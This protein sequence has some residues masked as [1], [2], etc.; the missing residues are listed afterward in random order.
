MPAEEVTAERGQDEQAWHQQQQGVAILLEDVDLFL[1]RPADVETHGTSVELDDVAH[2]HGWLGVEDGR[3]K[4]RVGAVFALGQRPVGSD[5]LRGKERGAIQ[6][7]DCEEISFVS[8]ERVVAELFFEADGIFSCAVF[9]EEAE[10]AVFPA[11]QVGLLRLQQRVLQHA[12][13]HK[14]EQEKAGKGDQEVEEHQLRTDRE[15]VHA[16]RSPRTCSRCH[17][18]FG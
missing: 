4:D 8:D 1:E 9:A 3:A 11:L 15:R 14:P 17:G 6:V 7:M 18:Q 13:A 16:V 12:E 5:A 10:E 2:H